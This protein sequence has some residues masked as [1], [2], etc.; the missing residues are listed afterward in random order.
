M[1]NPRLAIA[2]SVGS[3][4]NNELI[5]DG[6]S[7]VKAQPTEVIATPIHIP[8]RSVRLTLTMLPAP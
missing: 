4:V 6:M 7:S 3:T 8:I 5:V 2:I 1:R